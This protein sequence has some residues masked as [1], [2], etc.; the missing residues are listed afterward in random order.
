MKKVI[1]ILKVI[2]FLAILQLL[3][4][5]I[6]EFLFLFISKTSINIRIINSIIFI[7]YSIILFLM[8]KKE[9]INLDL[10][11]KKKTYIFL[12]IA[13]FLFFILTIFI[14]KSNYKDVIFLISGAIIV[15]LFEELLFRTY[16]W[17]KLKKDYKDEFI[18]YVIITIL[19][20]LW[21]F[22]YI[23]TVKT[24]MPLNGKVFTMNIMYYK[25]IT[26]L[27]FGVI[28]GFC[29]YK[30]KN[31]YSSFLLHSFLNMLGK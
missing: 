12:F 28:T 13:L 18:V 16:L 9:K 29:K 3:R 2:V 20:G 24:M 1:P 21:H 4:A 5:S 8:I 7:V 19:F 14:T 15:P 25:I 23:D 10:K 27:V 6:T 22:G 17:E 31:S 26:G 30:T 11:D